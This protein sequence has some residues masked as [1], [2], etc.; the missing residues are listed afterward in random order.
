MDLQ[1]LAV[2]VTEFMQFMAHRHTLAPSHNV[3]WT[4]PTVTYGQVKKEPLHGRNAHLI[5][6]P[7][8]SYIWGCLKEHVYSPPIKLM[9]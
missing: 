3:S 4:E 8:D 6:N 2:P 5:M 9:A 1:M 7:V